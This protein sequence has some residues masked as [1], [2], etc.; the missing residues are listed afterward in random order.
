[1]AAALA[2]RQALDDKR[3]LFAEDFARGRIGTRFNTFEHRSRILR[4]LAAKINEMPRNNEE[5]RLVSF[6][7]HRRI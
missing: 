5:K 3:R 7:S 1:V 6:E 2:R 4:Q